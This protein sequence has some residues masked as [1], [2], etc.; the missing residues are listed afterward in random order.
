MSSAAA[1]NPAISIVTV[2]F[3]G[4]QVLPVTMASVLQQTWSPLEYVLVDGASTDGTE[5]FIRE[6]SSDY[7]RSGGPISVRWVS[8][9]DEGLYHAMNKG[10][11]MATGEWV[12]FLNAGDAFRD[13]DT[14][15][16]MMG[17]RTPDTDVLF[18]ETML[19]DADRK[20]LGTR[21]ER[22]TQHL[23]ERLDWRSLRLG[24]VVCHQAFLTRRSLA[25]DYIAGNLAADIDWIIR[26]LKR[27]RR[28]VHTH[29]VVV[30]Y[31]T[32]GVSRQRHRQSLWDRFRVLQ[33]H[34]GFFPNLWNHVLI[35]LRALF[36]RR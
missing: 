30:D 26:I 8:E 31:L 14:L 10:L 22:T 27:S 32:G 24:M 17:Q 13:P 1:E 33:R 12:L 21:S 23:P 19:V 34:F 18:G 35:F 7:A 11:H 29:L 4:R 2:V 3:N 9:P 36:L 28:V 16:R 15:V 6:V 5:A 20:P 25:P